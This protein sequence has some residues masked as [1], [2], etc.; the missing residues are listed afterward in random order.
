MPANGPTSQ[1]V[2]DPWFPAYDASAVPRM[3][4]RGALFK[5]FFEPY[6]GRYNIKPD[7]NAALLPGWF[8]RRY[9]DYL[10]K[11]Q[12]PGLY[13]R[14]LRS[15]YV[16]FVDNPQLNAAVTGIR[17]SAFIGVF[18][19]AVWDLGYFFQVL[20]SHPD[21][22]PEVGEPSKQ[23]KWFD[24][25]SAWNWNL[26]V[27][28]ALQS[29]PRDSAASL[30]KG[31]RAVFAGYLT[32]FALD[33]VFFHE[34]GHWC[35]GHDKFARKIRKD[36]GP[37]VDETG[38]CQLPAIPSQLIELQADS[39]AVIFMVNEWFSAL[40]GPQ[41]IFKFAGEA[42]RV[43]SIAMAFTFVLF[44]QER[45]REIPSVGVNPHPGMLQ[46]HPHPSIRLENAHLEAWKTAGLF[47]RAAVS[48]FD[49][50]WQKGMRTVSEICNVLKIPSAVW[51]ADRDTV[52]RTYRLLCLNGVGLQ[53]DLNKCSRI[54]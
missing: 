36:F 33:F 37:F 13:S 4:L 49:A 3:P 39:F 15:A 41:S 8:K 50:S 17:K 27:G 53:D 34:I 2:F 10:R 11:M 40:Y 23:V 54:A 45:S 12:R 18:K 7:E 48:E 9:W 51:H 28:A 25:L 32:M 20:L 35:L 21:V 44:G 22:L 24:D 30:A 14:A 52:E 42:L 46:S 29:L 47:S 5:K 31:E 19:G 16:D 1:F 26:S 6:G 38:P 43:W